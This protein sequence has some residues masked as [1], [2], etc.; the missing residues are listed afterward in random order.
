M[1][2][3]RRSV[4]ICEEGTLGKISGGITEEVA[5]E[6]GLKQLW[7]D[8]CPVISL[9]GRL[10]KMSVHRVSG[11]VGLGWGPRCAF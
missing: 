8:V 9:L 7:S 3:L 5:F 10:C 2:F 6:L 1:P 11:S 4:G